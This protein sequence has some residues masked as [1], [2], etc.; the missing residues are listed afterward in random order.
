MS[1]ITA[2]LGQVNRIAAIIIAAVAASL[3]AY[4]RSQASAGIKW[5]FQPLAR[6]LPW[7][8]TP[9]LEAE[10]L[11][12]EMTVADIF[13]TTAD[14]R[15]ATYEKTGDYVVNAEPL[16][17][18]YEGVTAS[19]TASGFSTELGAIVQ[20]TTEHGFLVSRI[21]LGSVF[22]V[23]VR[24]RNV[25]RVQL[26]D[27]FLAEEEHWTQEIAVP[28]KHLTLRVH[29]PSGRPPKL[30]RSKTLV[31]LAHKQLGHGAA[32]AELFGQPAIVWEID[33]PKLGDIYKL[34]W[35]W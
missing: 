6:R 29:F 31:G 5:L 11:A 13:L 7:N 33:N 25:F 30:V 2:L 27:C 12:S 3:L 19:G 32:I 4:F 20:T 18:Y 22:E 28:T 35:R 21:D 15:S 23:G 17:L 16:N 10:K 14:G 8:Q 26:E 1:L 9:P 34:E 24:F